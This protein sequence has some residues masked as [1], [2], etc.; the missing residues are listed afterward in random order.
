[1]E[2][3]LTETQLS[4]AKHIPGGRFAVADIVFTRPVFGLIKDYIAL[5]AG[6]ISGALTIEDYKTMLREAGFADADVEIIKTYTASDAEALIPA[7]VRRKLTPDELE[8]LVTS[9]V[10]A[11]VRARKAR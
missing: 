9:F 6:C 11:F 7:D 3:A 8:Q 2:S 5:W 4:A 1:M 10:S